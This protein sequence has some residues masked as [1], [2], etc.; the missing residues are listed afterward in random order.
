LPLVKDCTDYINK[1]TITQDGI[2]FIDNLH[3][4][5]AE[6]VRTKELEHAF[7]LESVRTNDFQS[8]ERT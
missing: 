5:V 7:L 1:V 8:A 2:V 4:G 3:I 6:Y